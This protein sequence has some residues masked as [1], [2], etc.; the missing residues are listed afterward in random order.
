MWN[1]SETLHTCT[2]Y[3]AQA[4]YIYNRI[5]PVGR[6]SHVVLC[7]PPAA[8][9]GTTSIISSVT[10][11]CRLERHTLITTVNFQPA[12]L[13]G[14]RSGGSDT[15]TGPHECGHGPSEGPSRQNHSGGRWRKRTEELRCPACFREQPTR[16][17]DSKGLWG[18]SVLRLAS[19]FG[20]PGQRRDSPDTWRTP[21]SSCDILGPLLCRQDSTRFFFQ[22]DSAHLNLR[23]EF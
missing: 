20:S 2:R 17:Y 18:L 14:D 9:F 22:A 15:K 7:Y 6:K 8:T 5:G 1:P 10:S 21:S 11:V 12:K 4:L 13:T 3:H 19:C 23:F 16:I